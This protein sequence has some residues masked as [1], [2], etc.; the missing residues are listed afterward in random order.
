MNTILGVSRSHRF[1]PNSIDRDNAIFQ[2]VAVALRDSGY[3]V[4]SVSEDDLTKQS[5]TDAPCLVYSM[6]RSENALG[7]LMEAEAKGI[8]VI[9]SAYALTKG[10]RT[11]LARCFERYDL[12]VAESDSFDVKTLQPA[13]CFETEKGYWLKRGDA[14][15]QNSGDV[16]FVAS[17]KDLTEAA[18]DYQA[19][20]I[21]DVLLSPHIEGDLVK[22]YGV[23]DTD[24]FHL[25]YPTRE[26]SFSKFGLERF[27]GSPTGYAFSEDALKKSAD[28]CAAVSG[29]TVYGGD[30][31]VRPDGSF[32][33]IDFNDWPSFSR[34][35]DEAAK[36]IAE[37]LRK[38]IKAKHK[39]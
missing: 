2:A 18:A 29:F 33:I 36:A 15:A 26:G 11:A 20:G 24:F 21:T 3:E 10:T 12:P 34:C 1:S 9:N 13:L 27:N 6:A 19:R 35:C 38:I 39:I 8:P 17:Q 5:L 32:L 37:R 28:A 14:C 31:V 4:E 16:R 22:F 7:I 30:A 23:E 25:Y